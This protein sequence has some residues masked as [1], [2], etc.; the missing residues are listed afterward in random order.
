VR[1]GGGA[2]YHSRHEEPGRMDIIDLIRQKVAKFPQL[3]YGAG[4]RH[5][6]ID[7]PFDHGFAIDVTVTMKGIVVA[8]DRWY[9]RF[10]N[11]EDAL[12]CFDFAFS[13]RCRVR[14]DRAG[15]TDFRWTLECRYDD[16]WE[17]DTS[18]TSMLYPFWKPVY[19]RYLQNTK[20]G[21]FD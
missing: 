11:P 12:A 19:S 6:H 9:E 3:R 10:D 15:S 13:D 5:I 8:F 14:V 7:A 4:P 2:G 21:A 20:Q 18:V 1:P 17:K 16:E